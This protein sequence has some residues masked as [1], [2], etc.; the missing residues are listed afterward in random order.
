MRRRAASVAMDKVFYKISEVSEITG[1]EPYVL[2]FWETEFST[3]HP[4][5]SRG[6]QRIYTRAEIDTILQ[7][8]QLLYEERLTIAGAR[9]RISAPLPA[10][11]RTGNAPTFGWIRGELESLLLLLK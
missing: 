3:L 10:S 4:Q 7:I 11:Q 2:R 9:K 5:K 1:L 6:N 8:K